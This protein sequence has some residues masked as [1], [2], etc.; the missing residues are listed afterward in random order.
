MGVIEM[1]FF[2]KSLSLATSVQLILP[3]PR[4]ADVAVKPLPTLYLLHGMG[5]DDTAWLYK[6]NIERYATEAGLAVIM[7]DGELSCYENM[8]H[9]CAYRDYILDEL[10]RVMRDC[11]PLSDKREDNFIAGCSMGGFGALKLGLS[12]PESYAAIGCFSAAHMEYQPDS[13]RNKHMLELVY[14]DKL[15]EIEAQ[16]ERDALKPDKPHLSVWH[17]CGDADVLKDN[18]LRTRDFMEKIP[19]LDYHFEMLP[20]RHNW[21]LWDE[22]ARRF[23]RSLK[24]PEPEVALL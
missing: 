21:A 14:G 10:P 20:G 8:A 24:L 12:R 1:R 6:T 9:G 11:F 19:G 13:F 15:A 5:D 18:A 2:S 3:M 4:H 17:A 7:P 22:M 23:I 16:I